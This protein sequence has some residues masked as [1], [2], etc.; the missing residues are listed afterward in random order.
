MARHNNSL[1]TIAQD[2]KDSTYHHVHI[3]A[4]PI[5]DHHVHY[6]TQIPIDVKNLVNSLWNNLSLTLET[7]R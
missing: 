4:S 2:V 1:T 7:L 6:H 5:P 3:L